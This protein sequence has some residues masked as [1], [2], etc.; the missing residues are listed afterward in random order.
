VSVLLTT[1]LLPAWLRRLSPPIRRL[2][3]APSKRTGETAV[4]R[5][6]SGE[7]EEKKGPQTTHAKLCR[8]S[9]PLLQVA[10]GKPI[11]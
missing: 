8:L 3:L 9:K 5:Q 4:T 10:A 11:R 2:F 6:Q 1:T 7:G